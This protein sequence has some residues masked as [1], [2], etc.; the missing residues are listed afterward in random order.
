MSL[1]VCNGKRGVVDI[2][3]DI[4]VTDGGVIFISDLD[5]TEKWYTLGMQFYREGTHRY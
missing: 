5:E 2:H 3:S 1:I 4:I